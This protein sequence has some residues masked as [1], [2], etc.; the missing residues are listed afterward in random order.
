M[1][2]GPNANASRPQSQN[3]KVLK[4]I[5]NTSLSNNSVHSGGVSE[6]LPTS[7]D[8]TTQPTDNNQLAVLRETNQ[9]LMNRLV[10]VLK[11]L[12]MVKNNNESVEA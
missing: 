5:Q 3:L 7:K 1:A 6:T 10:E 4:N 9:R 8:G 12:E 11:V 2:K